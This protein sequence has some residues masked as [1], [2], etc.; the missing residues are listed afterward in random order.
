M[1]PAAGASSR[2]CAET[3]RGSVPS[4]KG[5][6]LHSASGPNEKWLNW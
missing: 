3:P 4:W 1:G 5:P 6:S 2:G